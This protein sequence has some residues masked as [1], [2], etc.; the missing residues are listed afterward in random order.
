MK[1]ILLFIPAL[2]II[3]NHSVLSCT[4][5]VISGKA[6]PDGRPL[7][8]KHRDTGF[9]QNKLVQF[10][11]TKYSYIG[12]VNSKDPNNKSVWIGFNS[13]G[14]AIM[15]TASYNLNNDTIRQSGLEGRLMKRAL[16]ECANIDEFE[17]LL[18]SLK[19]PIKLEANF[20]VID[21][22]GG[23]A[24][25]ELGNFSYEKI[26]AN[27]PKIAPYGYVVRTNY[28][29]TGVMGLASGYIRLE[30][31]DDLIRMAVQERRLTPKA[32]IQDVSRSL[33][34][35]LTKVDLYDYSNIPENNTTYVNFEDFIPRKNTSSAAVVQGV[36]KGEDPMYSTM[37][38]ALGW[39]LST[40]CV[41]VWNHTKT[42]LPSIL[43]YDKEIKDSPMCAMG[44][45]VKNKCYSFNWGIKSGKYM[46]VNALLN[47]D[48][49][50]I[51]QL[52]EPFEDK[53]FKKA[54]AVL[55]SWR[56]S[57]ID[58]SEMEDFYDWVDKEIPA[59][60][61]ETFNVEIKNK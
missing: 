21:A 41:P 39:P 12:L 46:N 34:H 32:I 17:Q 42:E 40:V 47:A 4:S 28:S 1:K 52:L 30:T 6:T 44:M 31:A 26:D 36:K 3:I 61:K 37:W 43:L 57:K 13:A 22:N 23:A 48:D 16:E 10:T 11:G 33:Y 35:S 27:D 24:Y 51:I 8:W 53:I 38:T 19:H 50:G 7:L 49:S 14:F 18:K 60:Y 45:E 56:D 59:F 55:D 5:A 2:L 58:A 9:L 25:F 15:N 54:S 20:G 29:T